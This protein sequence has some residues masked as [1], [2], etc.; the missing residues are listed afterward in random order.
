MKKLIF[1]L[2]IVVA[3]CSAPDANVPEKPWIIYDAYYSS[4]NEKESGWIHYRYVGVNGKTESFSAKYGEYQ[5]GDTI[6]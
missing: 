4:K 6:K 1:I 5:I 3:G 2:L